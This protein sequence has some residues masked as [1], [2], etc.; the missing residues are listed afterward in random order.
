[1]LWQ[2]VGIAGVFLFAWACFDIAM[3]HL[4]ER[5]NHAALKALYEYN[6][7]DLPVRLALVG[8]ARFYDI[9]TLRQATSLAGVQ[10]FETTMPRRRIS[11]RPL[12]DHACH[13]LSS[14][15]FEQG[16]QLMCSLLH[17]VARGQKRRA[18]AP[19]E[20]GRPQYPLCS[21]MHWHSSGRAPIGGPGTVLCMNWSRG[22]TQFKGRLFYGQSMPKCD[23]PFVVVAAESLSS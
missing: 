18:V 5:T 23:M 1:M 8:R 16:I 15:V 22:C 17:R 19:K 9:L 2:A 7:L 12:P 13:Q 20:M 11:Y 4:K 3:A 6:S 21:S 14:R 10:S